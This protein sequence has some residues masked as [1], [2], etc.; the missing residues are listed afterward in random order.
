MLGVR[1][2]S[3]GRGEGLKLEDRGVCRRTG[4]RIKRTKRGGGTNRNQAFSN[5]CDPRLTNCL[6]KG[7]FVDRQAQK[8]KCLLDGRDTC[9]SGLEDQIRPRPVRNLKGRRR[10]IVQG[11]AVQLVHDDPA[12][13][14]IDYEKRCPLGFAGSS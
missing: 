14:R 11:A 9:F 7:R 2:G 5:P 1:W 8:A 10:A 4:G 3:G 12:E 6:L 13:K